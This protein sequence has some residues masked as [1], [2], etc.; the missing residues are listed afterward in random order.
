MEIVNVSPY[1]ARNLIKHYIQVS[2]TMADLARK[3]GGDT[4]LYKLVKERLEA[5]CEIAIENIAS[6]LN[7]YGDSLAETRAVAAGDGVKMDALLQEPCGTIATRIPIKVQEIG[8]RRVG[9]SDAWELILDGET[10]EGTAIRQ[11]DAIRIFR[12]IERL[13]DR[14][15][16]EKKQKEEKKEGAE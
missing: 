7:R 14:R 12:A 1:M 10:L 9:T 2:D 8:F 15:N 13:R 11:I 5:E 3:E 4:N 6:A 16:A